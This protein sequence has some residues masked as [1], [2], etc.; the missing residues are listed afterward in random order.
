VNYR[1]VKRSRNARAQF[2]LSSSQRQKNIRGA[3]KIV[4]AFTAKSVVIVGDI[5]TT[6]NAANELAQELKRAGAE[7]V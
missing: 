5:V 4:V 3:F 7:D 6:G 1:I 2:N